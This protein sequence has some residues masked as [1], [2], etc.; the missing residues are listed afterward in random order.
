MNSKDQQ[1]QQQL[2]AN[3]SKQQ[4]RQATAATRSKD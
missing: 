2:P 1:L 3:T 4:Q